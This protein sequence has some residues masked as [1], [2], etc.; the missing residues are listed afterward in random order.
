MFGFSVIPFFKYV[1]EESAP[2]CI[3]A[4][5]DRRVVFF[6]LKPVC[7]AARNFRTNEDTA[8]TKA[9]SVS[10]VYDP[11]RVVIAWVRVTSVHS[12]RRFAHG[13]LMR[14]KLRK[15]YQPDCCTAALLYTAVCIVVVQQ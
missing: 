7:I 8:M 5:K 10:C 14:N 6:A 11:P 1:V 9:S 12:Q 2:E 13:Q 4:S 15:M 3:S